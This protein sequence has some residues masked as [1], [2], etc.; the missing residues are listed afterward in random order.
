MRR[1]RGKINS[2]KQDESAFGKLQSSDHS[3]QRGF[4]AA[5]CTQQ[6]DRLARVHFEGNIFEQW[7]LLVGFF[8]IDEFKH[9]DI[10]SR[11]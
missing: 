2:V 8:D 4:S 1:K 6:T 9:G 7:L 11:L 5:R 10:I 3:Q